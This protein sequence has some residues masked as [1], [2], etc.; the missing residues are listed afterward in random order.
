MKVLIIYDSMYGNTQKV[1]EV[2]AT[3]FPKSDQVK[4]LKVDDVSP[5]DLKV[6]LLVVGSPTQGGRPTVK[7][8]EFFKKI[9]AN[10]L[11]GV[12]V[13]AFDTRIAEQERGF[14][15]RLLMK[16]IGYAAPKI[17]TSL[18]NL[19]GRLIAPPEGFMVEDKE[20]PLK[21]GELDRSEVWIKEILKT[22]N[23]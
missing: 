19:G 16:T 1:A 17:A 21:K 6:D 9:P 20:G 4:L 5:A 10:A 22:K 3:A 7:L 2:L 14:A 12:K 23:F 13:A 11:Q 18:K 15:L 8:L